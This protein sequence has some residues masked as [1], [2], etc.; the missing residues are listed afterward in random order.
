MTLELAKWISVIATGIFAVI[1]AYSKLRPKDREPL[2]A[3]IALVGGAFAFLLALLT[4]S[5]EQAD[6]TES[7]R[8][9]A[10]AAKGQ[11]EEAKNVAEGLRET[12]RQIRRTQTT[13]RAIEFG[14]MFIL[15]LSRPPLKDYVDRLFKEVSRLSADE[16]SR[17]S[18][19]LLSSARGG[20]GRLI[21]LDVRPRSR[22]DPADLGYPEVARFLRNLG[23]S[24]EVYAQPKSLLDERGQLRRH[25]DRP[26]PDF[27]AFSEVTVPEAWRIGLSQTMWV[28]SNSQWWHRSSRVDSIEDLLGAQ[29][30]VRV[31]AAEADDLDMR[32][33]SDRVVADLLDRTRFE[34]MMLRVNERTVKLFEFRTASGMDDR[35]YFEV[36]RLP[37]REEELFQSSVR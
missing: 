36:Y 17:P 14:P 3:R 23:V 19:D 20:D 32:V 11:A 31:R 15:P 33:A 34:R 12:L 35:D 8:E 29:V 22:L 26:R 24:L 18:G 37:G 4:Q 28:R 25:R 5:L 27:V 7:A 10:V 16:L 13:L 2:Y 9:A 30:L 6:R 21:A 1:A